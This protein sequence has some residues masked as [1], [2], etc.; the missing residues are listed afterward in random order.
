MAAAAGKDVRVSTIELFFDLVFVFSITQLTSLLVHEPNATGV[1]RG[2]L[3][4][5]VLWWM[6]GGYAWLT[7]AVPPRETGYRILLLCGMA[8]FLVAALAIPDAFGDR[9]V[10]FGLAYLVVNAIH[11]GMFMRASEHATIRATL[12][13]AP[14]NLVS[15]LLVLAAGFVDGEAD[16]ALWGG[17]FVLQWFTPYLSRIGGFTIAAAHFVERHG[18]IL[19][20]ALGESVVALG[21]GASELRLEGDLVL[22]ALLGLL[23][24]TLLWWLYFDGE[25]ERAERALL[26]APAE[27]RPW[28][29][30]QAFG[31]AFLPMLGGIV[32]AA[33]GVEEVI[34]HA[35]AEVGLAGSCFLAGGVAAYLVGLVFF[36]L[37]LGTGPIRFRLAAA[38]LA[39]ASVPLGIEV[40]GVLEIAALAA[41]LLAV[42][43][44]E[45]PPRT[46]G[47]L[48]STV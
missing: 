8:A 29:A 23:L 5:G 9:G 32:A 39:P 7:N 40:A 26:E 24:A 21:I 48:R 47:R 11:L 22:A 16:W 36:R 41:L 4:L 3:V 38:S 18:L 10:H 33:A 13:L 12:R 1:A 6:F 15:A 30:L 20:I 42:V 19:I 44:F 14:F 43:A 37:V 34:G 31:Y 2:V 28:L 46:S 35:D 25:D 45:R 27:R 17:A